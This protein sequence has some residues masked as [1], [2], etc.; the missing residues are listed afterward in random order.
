MIH[1]DNQDRNRIN[2]RAFIRNNY[3]MGNDSS[4]ATDKEMMSKGFG[5]WWRLKLNRLRENIDSDSELKICLFIFF[6]IS[7]FFKCNGNGKRI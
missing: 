6:F 1:Q 2:S 3:L 7:F 5:I 4:V